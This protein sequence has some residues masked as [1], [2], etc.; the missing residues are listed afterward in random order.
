MSKCKCGPCIYVKSIRR[1]T[2]PTIRFDV[3]VDLSEC[4]VVHVAFKPSARHARP[5]VKAK[6]A[7]DMSVTDGVTSVAV[8]LTQADTLGWPAGC[9]IEVQVRYKS[10][11]MADATGICRLRV[12]RIL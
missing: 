6:E 10:G 7:L 3:P 2:T 11:E 12:E 4:D 9:D 8:L 1:G 5:V